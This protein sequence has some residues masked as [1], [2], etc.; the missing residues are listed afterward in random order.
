MGLCS[1]F[2]LVFRARRRRCRRAARQSKAASSEAAFAEEK[3][4]L[5]E[6]QAQDAPP[7]YGDD[8]QAK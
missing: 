7:E 3:A 5:M 1:C 4:G 6:D 2:A 8:Q